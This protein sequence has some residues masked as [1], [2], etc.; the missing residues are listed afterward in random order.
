MYIYIKTEE[1]QFSIIEADEPDISIIE[2]SDE[3]EAYCM[4]GHLNGGDAGYEGHAIPGSS[5]NGET[6]WAIND[7]SGSTIAWATSEVA[8]E[9]LLTHLN[10]NG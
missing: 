1:G 9:G 7:P 4:V 5:D 3:E 8:A 2:F 10:R 6:E